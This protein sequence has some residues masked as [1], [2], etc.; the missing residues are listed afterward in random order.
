MHEDPVT[1]S[2]RVT[3]SAGAVISM[4]ETD[5]WGADTN[6]SS[7]SAFQPKKFTSYARDGNGT[8]E[9]MFRR[10]NRW[11]SRFDQP[12][13]YDGSYDAADPQT[14]NRYAYVQGDP[15]NF[16]DP[17]GLEMA[18]TCLVDG[19]PVNCSTA[20]GLVNSGAG[21]VGSGPG[22]YGDVLVVNHEPTFDGGRLYQS[23]YFY[24][25]TGGYTDIGGG[26]PQETDVC[27]IMANTAQILADTAL[28]FWGNAKDA[29]GQFDISFSQKYLGNNGIG[30][31]FASASA[32]FSAIVQP[33]TDA[34][35]EGG[36]RPEFKEGDPI[37]GDQTHHFA[38]FLTAGINGQYSAA[39]LHQITDL[40]NQADIRLGDAAYKI[41][42]DLRNDPKGLFTIGERILKD[43]CGKK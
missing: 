35:G 4:I 12:D 25:L 3:N 39:S 20:F 5:P 11:Q 33:K 6:R 41:G 29:L 28:N 34:V 43:I 21:T 23:L 13:P 22:F 37:S 38:A 9:A 18:L 17:T 26:G 36:F 31:T 16:V 19:M 32:F 40:F 14:F 8:D 42:D 24:F 27:A 7:N 1:K 2:K 15:V 10:Y 30:K